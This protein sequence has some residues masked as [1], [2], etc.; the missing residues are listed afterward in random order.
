MTLVSRKVKAL[1]VL[2]L[3]SF[4]LAACANDGHMKERTGMLL[5]GATGALLGS[6]FGKGKGK[7]AA[8]A[9]GTLAGSMVGSEL[10]RSLDEQD[11][12]LSR[13][14]TQQALESGQS[15]NWNNNNSGHSGTITPTRTYT[16]DNTQCREY[17]H[18]V[19]INGRYQDAYGTA[20]RQPDGT[21]RLVN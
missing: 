11:R 13:G 12:Q 9:V 14:A 15:T 3:S 4:L 5:G 21:W 8:I 17:Q 18:R 6:Q 20:C 7:M 1:T 19:K 10:G 16:A 2:S